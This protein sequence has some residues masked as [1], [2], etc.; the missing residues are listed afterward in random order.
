MRGDRP[1]KARN[2][3]RAA[4]LIARAVYVPWMAHMVHGWAAGGA[5]L[6]PKTNALGP[7]VPGVVWTGHRPC[8][9]L[10]APPI[11]GRGVRS[12]VLPAVGSSHVQ[13]L[14]FRVGLGASVNFF[15]F[16]GGQYDHD[17]HYT[18]Y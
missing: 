11:L 15:Y 16:G 12:R 4:D 5:L 1:E 13:N 17:I 6:H 18:N 2:Q 9:D 10:Y 7:P 3:V 8:S 14:G